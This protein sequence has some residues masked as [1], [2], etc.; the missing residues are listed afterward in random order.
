[1]GVET[2]ETGAG[3]GLM[4]YAFRLTWDS[5]IVVHIIRVVVPCVLL[6]IVDATT[7]ATLAAGI[8]A[9]LGEHLRQYFLS[10]RFANVFVGVV[11]HN[12]L[13]DHKRVCL[14]GE[15]AFDVFVIQIAQ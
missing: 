4:R 10:V 5:W 15:K 7:A 2:Q 9:A 3:S 14:A 8:I 13:P 1:M 11:C 12:S 6:L